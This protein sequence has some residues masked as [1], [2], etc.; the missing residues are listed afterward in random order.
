LRILIAED[1]AMSRQVLESSVRHLGHELCIVNNGLE[2]WEIFNEAEF[3]VVLSDWMMPEIDG[4]ELCSRIRSLKDRHY[5]YFILVT[6]KNNKEDLITALESG[7]DDFIAKPYYHGE[8]VARIRAGE[9]MLRLEQTLLDKIRSLEESTEHVRKL[10]G[11]LPICSF[12]KKI[13]DD[14]NYWHKVETYIQDRS[15]I[16]FSHSVCPECYTTHYEQYVKDQP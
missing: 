13:R 7:V 8:L 15:R 1:D 14:S 12:C 16:L 6:A 10:Q 11:L 5:V 4:L 2:A 3:S 9:R